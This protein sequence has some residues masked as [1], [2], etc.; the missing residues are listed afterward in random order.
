MQ[1]QKLAYIAHG[2]NLVVNREGLISEP[3]EAWTY[4][5]VYRDLYDHTKYFGKEP[6]G[7]L[8]SADD[9]EI[10]GLFVPPSKR[11]A[12]YKAALTS[13]EEQVIGHVWNRYGKLNA[14]QL[15]EMTHQFGTPWYETFVTKGRNRIIPDEIISSHYEQ[16]AERAEAT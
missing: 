15:S 2:W 12:P 4:G 5:P 1:L 10:A 3:V 7:H 11:S 16:L 8:L 14:F 9:S 13:R 6:I